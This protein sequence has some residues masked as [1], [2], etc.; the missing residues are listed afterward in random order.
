ME[1]D[2]FIGSCRELENVC[3]CF[4]E[5][6]KLEWVMRIERRKTLRIPSIEKGEDSYFFR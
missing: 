4:L 1:N 3:I 2:G 5:Y 6:R